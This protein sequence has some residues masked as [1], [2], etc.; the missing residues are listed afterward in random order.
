MQN[1]SSLAYILYKQDFLLKTLLE[2]FLE[3][4]AFI[5]VD[6][7]RDNDHSSFSLWANQPGQLQKETSVITIL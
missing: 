7:K 2:V 3:Q 5:Q 6:M 4:F 1:F